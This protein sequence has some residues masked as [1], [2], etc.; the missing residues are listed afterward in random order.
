MLIKYTPEK[1]PLGKPELYYMG[2]IRLA[3]GV[4]NVSDAIK[5]HPS[6][7][8]LVKLGAIEEVKVEPKPLEEEDKPKPGRKPK[9]PESLRIV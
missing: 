4:N 5:S 1:N 6:Y 2:R 7:E 9:E 8:M 3:R